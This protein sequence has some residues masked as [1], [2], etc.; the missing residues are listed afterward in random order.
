MFNRNKANEIEEDKRRECNNFS[1]ILRK[2]LSMLEKNRILKCKYVYMYILYTNRMHFA[3][4]ELCL[5]FIRFIFTTT[6]I[7]Y[8][9]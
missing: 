3:H 2:S 4:F 9:N 5:V 6:K 1:T 8:S 7:F